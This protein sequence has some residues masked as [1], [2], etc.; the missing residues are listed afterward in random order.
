MA[1]NKLTLNKSELVE[2]ISSTVS[3]IQEQEK[4][5]TMGDVAATMGNFG[6]FFNWSWERTTAFGDI[7]DTK[8]LSRTSMVFTS[9]EYSMWDT[10]EEYYNFELRLKPS[11]YLNEIAKI[12]PNKKLTIKVK[13]M[14]PT[15]AKGTNKITVTQE[16]GLR[17]ANDPALYNKYTV[18]KDAKT[19]T[20]KTVPSKGTT[21]SWTIN[22]DPSF[23]YAQSEDGKDTY[24]WPI[25]ATARGDKPDPKEVIEEQVPGYISK[26]TA[27]ELDRAKLAK[28]TVKFTKSNNY[29]GQIIYEWTTDIEF[30]LGSVIGTA[31]VKLDIDMRLGIMG[32]IVVEEFRKAT[33]FAKDGT[34]PFSKSNWNPNNWSF[35]TKLDAL[36]FVL[37]IIAGFFT[38][39]AGWLV[40]ARYV[41]WAAYATVVGI[42]TIDYLKKGDHK[43]AGIHLLFEALMF[44]KPLKWFK[45]GVEWMKTTKGVTWLSSKISSGVK[46]I[47]MGQKLT[48]VKSAKSVLVL[49][50]NNPGARRMIRIIAEGGEEALVKLKNQLKRTGSYKDVTVEMAEEFIKAITKSNAKLAGKITII[51]ARKILTQSGKRTSQRLLQAL[52]AIPEMIVS[53]VILISLYDINMIMFP[54]KVY[55]LGLDPKKYKPIKT[56]PLSNLQE[57]LYEKM[58]KSD[59]N[60]KLPT[61]LTDLL[62]LDIN[63]LFG[64]WRVKDLI[65]TTKMP[66][67]TFLYNWDNVRASYVASISNPNVKAG[68]CAGIPKERYNLYASNIYVPASS[69]E[70]M[71]YEAKQVAKT[72]G[73][74]QGVPESAQKLVGR[75]DVNLK[76]K[77]DWLGGWRPEHNCQAFSVEEVIDITEDELV[78]NIYNLP[79]PGGEPDKNDGDWNRYIKKGAKKYYELNDNNCLELE[80]GD[81]DYFICENPMPATL[82][83]YNTLDSETRGCLNS[84]MTSLAAYDPIQ[85]N[86]STFVHWT[87]PPACTKLGVDWKDWLN[88]STIKTG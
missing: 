46:Y 59:I 3:T 15:G 85:K 32:M 9:K 25:N 80:V 17:Y 28:K 62:G 73:K 16:D 58:G 81:K 36:A 70:T 67:S 47:G 60:F 49:L 64:W 71:Q 5:K 82:K 14:P 72:A 88:E 35:N 39:G 66:D 50:K 42:N 61:T 38:E 79:P 10:G 21:I 69:A 55:L 6:A 19:E 20:I 76:L 2:I 31:R 57:Y 34:K 27:N 22:T 26:S 74:L 11:E 78:E 18:M 1:K 51:Q 12:F 30:Q 56:T 63:K 75:S 65:T 87:P 29:A 37:F 54:F 33:P 8:N 52:S 68:K 43:M 53:S 44:M 48:T 13:S 23:W 77:E 40:A 84:L 83:W 4:T 45:G 7:K 86:S 41:T 24:N